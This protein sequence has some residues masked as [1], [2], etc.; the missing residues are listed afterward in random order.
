M[1]EVAKVVT[2]IIATALTLAGLAG[3]QEKSVNPGINKHFEKASVPDFIKKFE[4][5]SREVYT[6]RAAIVAALNL[7]PGMAVADIGA[8]TGLFTRLIAE[9]VGP[10]GKVY[11]VDVTP[12]FLEHI[13]ADARKK[14]LTQVTTVR[15]PPNSVNLPP[16]S[17]DLAFICDTYHHFEYP[18]RTLASIHQALRP[19]GTLVVVE[20]DRRPGASKFILEHVR[21]PKEVFFSEIEAAGFERIDEPKPPVPGLKENF[22]AR[23]RKLPEA[24]APKSRSQ[25]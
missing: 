4:V 23:F 11:A 16:A 9:K 5:D 6:H 24:A 19:G 8:G 3:A 7:K 2:I 10:Q 13:A 22:F 12:E 21:A 20:M 18:A 1:Q 14:G 25:P 15:C 17:I